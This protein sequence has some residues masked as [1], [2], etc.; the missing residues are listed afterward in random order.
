M[1]SKMTDDD[2]F[3]LSTISTQLINLLISE[4]SNLTDETAK[5]WCDLCDETLET[6][7]VETD[8]ITRFY[9]P[10]GKIQGISPGRIWPF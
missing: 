6:F 10:F 1:N 7:S 5:Y 3:Q 8:S 9:R 2:F 4:N